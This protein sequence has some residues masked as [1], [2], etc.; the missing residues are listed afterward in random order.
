[1]SFKRQYIS[2]FFKE[3]D[4]DKHLVLKEAVI[5]MALP[6]FLLKMLVKKL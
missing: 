6:I 1:M 3:A 4:V 2:T 5:M